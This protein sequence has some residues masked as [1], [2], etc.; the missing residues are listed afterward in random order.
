MTYRNCKFLIEKG[1]YVYDDM[2]NKLDVFLLRNRITKDQYN[3]LMNMMEKTA[4]A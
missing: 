1:D 2:C 4:T 3:E